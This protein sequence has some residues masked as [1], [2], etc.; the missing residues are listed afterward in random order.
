MKMIELLEDDTTDEHGDPRISI[1]LRFK[2][3]DKAES[4]LAKRQKLRPPETD[5]GAGITDM[6]A[7]ME[8][9]DVQ[10][11]LDKLMFDRGYVKV[12]PSR[13]GRPRKDEEP[14]RAR[15]KEFKAA[16]N[17]DDDSGWRK[18]LGQPEGEA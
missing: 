14:I 8:S 6:K 11:M 3:F 4:W 1:E 18:M 10:Q 16:K 15:M 12:P 5:E 17:A 9:P 2:L 7:W 13:P